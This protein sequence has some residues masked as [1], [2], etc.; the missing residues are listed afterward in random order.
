LSITAAQSGIDALSCKTLHPRIGCQDGL[1]PLVMAVGDPIASPA[2]YGQ[3]K[4][5]QDQ[6]A[7]ENSPLGDAE[8][9]NESKA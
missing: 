1:T 6:R 4:A 7:I 9:T 8:I 3:A 5:H 2:I